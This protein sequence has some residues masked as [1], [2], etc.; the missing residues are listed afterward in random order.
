MKGA[1]FCSVVRFHSLFHSTCR[2]TFFVIL[3]LFVQDLLRW[4]W[5]L[6]LMT[7][8]TRY[9]CIVAD[10]NNYSSAFS[11]LTFP[12]LL[13]FC[14]SCSFWSICSFGNISLQYWRDVS[15]LLHWI[16]SDFWRDLNH[17]DSN[18]VGKTWRRQKCNKCIPFFSFGRPK[19][20]LSWYACSFASH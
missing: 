9:Y 13:T 5:S 10:L 7:S 19:S 11:S 15:E 16:Q 14:S 4:Y 12:F 17:V 1:T 6:S 2:V 20:K 18:R 3:F 8:L